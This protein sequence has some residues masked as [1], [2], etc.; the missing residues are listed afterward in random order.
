MAHLDFQKEAELL[1]SAMEISPL[2]RL[3]REGRMPEV[4]AAID[5]MS[6]ADTRRLLAL[7]I[8]LLGESLPR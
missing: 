8:A 6:Q 5:G 4:C 1:A 3:G 2:I 7:C